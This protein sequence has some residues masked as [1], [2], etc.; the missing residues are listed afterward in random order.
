MHFHTKLE[1]CKK[2]HNKNIL[3]LPIRPN[4]NLLATRSTKV[5]ACT[6]TSFYLIISFTKQLYKK[7]NNYEQTIT[8]FSSARTKNAAQRIKNRNKHVK[9]ACESL[10]R[11]QL[12]NVVTKRRNLC[13]CNGTQTH[14]HLVEPITI[15]SK[16][17]AEMHPGGFPGWYI[18]RNYLPGLKLCL[19]GRQMNMLSVPV[20]ERFFPRW[21]L[22]ILVALILQ[23]GS[24]DSVLRV[25]RWIHDIWVF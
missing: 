10:K 9:I 17:P 6:R 15:L 19:P 11:Y 13:D 4:D 14:H 16:C 23:L 3:T 2:S 21:Y 7:R 18:C 12:Y 1:I 24:R 5:N 8:S 25:P 20:E 22:K